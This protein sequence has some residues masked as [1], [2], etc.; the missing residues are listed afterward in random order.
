MVGIKSSIFGISASGQRNQLP[1]PPLADIHW[2]RGSAHLE[3]TE[4]VAANKEL[5]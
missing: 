1:Q 4:P 3:S 5:T 2:V